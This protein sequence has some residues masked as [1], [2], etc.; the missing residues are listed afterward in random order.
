MK[1][2]SRHFNA[3]AVN[4]ALRIAGEE[5]GIDPF[6]DDQFDD[7]LVDRAIFYLNDWNVPLPP[8]WR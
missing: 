1:S 4:E 5:L 6:D 7:V 3:E 2:Y 8:G